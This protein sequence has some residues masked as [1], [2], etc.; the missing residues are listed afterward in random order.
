VKEKIRI[1]N[2]VYED[3]G[4]ENAEYTPF[5]LAKDSDIVFELLVKWKPKKHDIV[6][7]EENGIEFKYIVLG[8]TI[9]SCI[10]APLF[11]DNGNLAHYEVIADD[12][13]A[14]ALNPLCFNEKFVAT[15]YFDLDD[16][17]ESIYNVEKDA[18]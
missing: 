12:L 10:L 13:I 8:N 6:Y 17:I 18:K 15:L 9:D 1:G 5:K 14:P 3:F 2:W 4:E 11:I 16:N 7:I